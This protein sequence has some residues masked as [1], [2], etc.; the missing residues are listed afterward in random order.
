MVSEKNALLELHYS[1]SAE[2]L[3][4][5]E[6]AVL[7]EHVAAT[8]QRVEDDNTCAQGIALEALGKLSLVVAAAWPTLARSRPLKSR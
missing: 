8:V 7:S 1:I 2:T 4:K 5:L 6:P 3:V